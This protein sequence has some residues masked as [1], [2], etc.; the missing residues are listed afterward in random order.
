V[1]ILFIA[2][3]C[4]AIDVARGYK[5]GF[6]EWKAAKKDR[7]AAYKKAVR[8][9]R[10]DRGHI[11]LRDLPTRAGLAVWDFG[12]WNRDVVWGGVK[13]GWKR[14]HQARDDWRARRAVRNQ[15]DEEPAPWEP[16]LSNPVTIGRPTRRPDG[17]PETDA[18]RRFFDL[19]ESGYRG[20]IDQDGYPVAT[21]N[22][23]SAQPQSA[24][25]VRLNT[26]ADHAPADW[27]NQVEK[28]RHNSA[29]TQGGTP[30][31]DV[32]TLE[33]L[34]AQVATL[35]EAAAVEIDDAKAD[36]ARAT[37]AVTGAQALWESVAAHWPVDTAAPFA[38]MVE[39]AQIALGAAEQKVQAA[40]KRAANVRAAE[41]ELGRQIAAEEAAR[42]A[43]WDGGITQAAPVLT[44]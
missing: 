39:D 43:G 44:G 2:A 21:L 24:K 35:A 28:D 31:S 36:L 30:M 6:K 40:D 14:R 8:A 41:D 11:R 19:R 5:T 32:Q 1:E 42:A 25:F 27:I 22:I 13:S 3:I 4:A 7:F 33:Q 34:K 17:Q 37:E 10:S 38:R 26:P 23:P 20:P 15:L 12:W 16:Q 9:R 18:D 29:P